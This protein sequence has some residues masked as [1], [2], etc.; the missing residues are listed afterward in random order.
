MALPYPT[1]GMTPHRKTLAFFLSLPRSLLI[2]LLLLAAFTI[3]FAVVLLAPALCL[4]RP[5]E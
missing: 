3:L 2:L 5:P 4:V 1:D